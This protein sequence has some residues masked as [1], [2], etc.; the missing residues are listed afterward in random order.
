MEG[1]IY[2][3]PL[4]TRLKILLNVMQYINNNSLAY[5][6]CFCAYYMSMVE[7]VKSITLLNWCFSTNGVALALSIIKCYFSSTLPVLNQ[8]LGLVSL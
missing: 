6:S 4:A 8:L 7:S 1:I 2:C 5:L 3:Q